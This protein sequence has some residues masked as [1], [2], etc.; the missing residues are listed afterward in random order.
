MVV[1][2]GRKRWVCRRVGR[3]GRVEALLSG[4]LRVAEVGVGGVHLR[5]V[6]V[7]ASIGSGVL[8]HVV[9]AGSSGLGSLVL[10]LLLMLLRV[11]ALVLLEILRALEGLSADVA[12]VRL[13]GGVDTDVRGDVVA[14]G[15]ADVAALPLA[16]E[17]EVVGRLAT[18]VVVT[19]MLVDVLGVVEDLAT[20]IPSAGDGLGGW[21]VLGGV[22][23]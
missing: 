5:R 6:R 16:G 18:D 9:G 12:V 7:G 14:L 15:T 20:V 17:A 3:G 19:E 23:G 1:G 21:T 8:G 22:R 4:E 11:D 10:T 2:A 13:E